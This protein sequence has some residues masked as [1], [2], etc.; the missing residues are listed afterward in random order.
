M[1]TNVSERAR[2]VPVLCSILHLPNEETA[3]ITGEWE[4]A[5]LASQRGLRGVVSWLLPPPP[6]IDDGV[7]NPLEGTDAAILPFD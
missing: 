7:L 5:A 3:T 2:C 4:Q 6:V 1:T